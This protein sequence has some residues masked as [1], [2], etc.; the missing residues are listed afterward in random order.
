M[1]AIISGFI[2]M[3][4]NIWKG[5]NFADLR[6]EQITGIW[7]TEV[8]SPGAS[9]NVHLSENEQMSASP[10]AYFSYTSVH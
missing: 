9:S 6:G 4:C 2:E 3:G 8:Y 10:D 7:H 1:L 5:F